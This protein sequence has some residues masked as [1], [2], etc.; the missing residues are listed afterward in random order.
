MSVVYQVQ[1]DSDSSSQVDELNSA[2][3]IS[4]DSEFEQD[5]ISRA[6]PTSNAVDP[7]ARKQPTRV[8]VR[9]VPQ[10]I[11]IWPAS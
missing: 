5:P 10:F 4:T 1:T 2:T 7:N 6:H 11:D 9:S 3:E 8:Q